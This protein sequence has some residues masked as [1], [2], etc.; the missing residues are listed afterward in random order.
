MGGEGAAHA[1]TRAK[2][3]GVVLRETSKTLFILY[4][5]TR[6]SDNQTFKKTF[7]LDILSEHVNNVSKVNNIIIR[8]L[9]S[10]EKSDAGQQVAGLCLQWSEAPSALPGLLSLSSS[11]L[12]RH[13][14]PD[15]HWGRRATDSGGLLDIGLLFSSFISFPCEI[16]VW[17]NGVSDERKERR[18][19]N[20]IS[21]WDWWQVGVQEETVEVGVRTSWPPD[22]SCS[23]EDPRPPRITA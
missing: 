18:A 21:V 9:H 14:G 1:S 5:Q 10:G 7:R 13:T 15:P 23:V 6:S 11:F 2:Q 8:W 19:G 12:V 17:E 22:P 3:S 16:I 20:L 4:L